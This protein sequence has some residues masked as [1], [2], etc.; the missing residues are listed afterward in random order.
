MVHDDNLEVVDLEALTP[1]SSAGKRPIEIVATTDS[2]EWSSSKGGVVSA[3]FKIQ[4]NGKVKKLNITEGNIGCLNDSEAEVD[5]PEDVIVRSTCDHI[6]SV[7]LTIYP[8]FQK[9]LDDPSYLQDKTI[10]VPTNEEVDA[11]NEYMLG[12]MKDEGKTYLR[13]LYVRQSQHIVLKK[14]FTL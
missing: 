14:Q 13:I 6:L 1:S 7:E 12:L 3:T 9:H 5:F 8:S 2:L 11:I 4:K 10:L